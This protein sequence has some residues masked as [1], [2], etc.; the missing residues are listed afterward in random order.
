MVILH[1]ILLSK[2]LWSMNKISF[3]IGGLVLLTFGLVPRSD[4]F[5]LSYLQL[6]NIEALSIGAYCGGDPCSNHDANCR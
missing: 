5:L 3:V 4:D 6:T 1:H 2:Y